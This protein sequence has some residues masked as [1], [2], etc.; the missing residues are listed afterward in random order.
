MLELLFTEMTKSDDDDEDDS[1][2]E[3]DI[4]LEGNLLDRQGVEATDVCC[5]IFLEGEAGFKEGDRE[6]VTLSINFGDSLTQETGVD[7]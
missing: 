3:Q 6:S 1:A 2:D 7:D 5:T 4:S